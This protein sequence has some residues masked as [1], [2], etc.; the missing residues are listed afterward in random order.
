MRCRWALVPLVVLLPAGCALIGPEETAHTARLRPQLA[1]DAVVIDFA[2]LERSVGDPYLDRELW[3]HTDQIVVDLDKKALLD[4]NGFRVGQVIGM[5][6]A[7]L[8]ELLKSDR[9]CL[10]PRRSFAHSGQTETFYLSTLPLAHCDYDLH[11]GGPTQEV[12]VDR[13]RFCLDV[14]PTLTPDGKTRLR[15]LPKVETG[16]QV[17]PFQP[18][19]EQAGWQFK[20]ERPNKAY[21]ALAWEVTLA[22]NEYLIVGARLDKPGT[23]G[24]RA[25]VEEQGRHPVQR[26]LVIRTNRSKQA[27]EEPTL[28]DTARASSSPPLAVQASLAGAI[29]ASRP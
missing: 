2:L 20:I 24:H 17:L 11:L 16:E 25:L 15:F 10:N 4:D 18:A 28:E 8:Q 29:R 12:S 22:P 21:P 6:P 13:A 19:P 27:T 3:T 14:T 1:A 9:C 5:T 7:D 23:L 26:V